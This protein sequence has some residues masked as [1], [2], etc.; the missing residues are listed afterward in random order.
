M[1]YTA[2]HITLMDITLYLL[3][4]ERTY[5]NVVTC[6]SVTSHLGL[7]FYHSLIFIIIITIMYMMEQEEKLDAWK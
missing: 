6:A 5:G 3:A 1:Q 4:I 2:T 7:G